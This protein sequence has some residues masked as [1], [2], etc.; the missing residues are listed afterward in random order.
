VPKGDL[1]RYIVFAILL[2]IFDILKKTAILGFRTVRT[3]GTVRT[4][5]YL[6]C[7]QLF[8][9]LLTLDNL[10]LNLIIGL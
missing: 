3:V 6:S 2:G 8:F 4:Q 10:P 1:Q 7:S 5:L 9:D